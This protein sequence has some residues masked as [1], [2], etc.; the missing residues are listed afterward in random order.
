MSSWTI[1]DFISELAQLEI[2]PLNQFPI[3]E[4]TEYAE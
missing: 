1:T 4:L 2:T 3:L